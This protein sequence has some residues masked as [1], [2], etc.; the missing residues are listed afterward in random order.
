M[1][2]RLSG[3]DPARADLDARVLDWI[4][5]WR[6]EPDAPEDEVRFDALARDLFAFQLE[7]CAPWARFCAARGVTPERLA[8]WRDIPPVPTASFK[9]IALRS[10]PAE[11]E[12]HVFR[13]SGTT[14]ERRGELHLDTLA[15]YDA[16]VVPSFVAH[17]LP[18]LARADGRPARRLALR[19]LAPSPGEAPDSSLSH[20]FGVLLR[21]LAPQLDAARSGFDVR[22]GA[23]TFEPLL[24]ALES[25]CVDD[26]PVA[27]CGT[28][29]AFVHLCDALAARGVALALPAGSRAFETGGFKARSRELTRAALRDAI[30]GA[31]GV[32]AERVVNQYGMTELASQFHDSVLRFPRTPRRK[33]GPPW[34][35]VRI[36]DPATGSDVSPGEVGVIVV[37]DLASTGS[38]CAIQTA[39]LGLSREDGFEVLGRAEGA[40]ARGCSLGAEALLV[41]DARA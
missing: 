2:A 17:V 13:T 26:V 28:A 7:R 39:D 20:M 38:V 30:E 24:A 23:L 14:G 3:G 36:V 16:S 35:R 5:S 34:A 6:G 18:E 22:G 19:A 31:L 29:F 9:E 4:A 12:V 40:D 10:F 8:S 1:S 41:G 37:V 27:L 25:A 33:L 11:R 21:R 15:L 32:P